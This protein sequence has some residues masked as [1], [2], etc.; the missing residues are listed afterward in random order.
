MTVETM[1]DLAVRE[2]LHSSC[3]RARSEDAF[4]MRNT[5][6]GFHVWVIDGASSI[7]ADPNQYR[8]DMT[9]PAWFARALSLLI[10]RAVGHAPLTKSTLRQAVG[11]CEARYMKRCAG[12]VPPYEYPLAAMTYAHIRQAGRVFVINQ[13]DFADC[14][15]HVERLQPTEPRPAIASPAFPPYAPFEQDGT[16]VADLRKR[17][18]AQIQDG[19]GTALTIRSESAGCGAWRRTRMLGPILLA[20]GSDGIERAW[21]S[22]GLLNLRQASRIMV[23][24]RALGLLAGM[25]RWESGNANHGREIK[26]A[27]DATLIT[28]VL[29]AGNGLGGRGPVVR[30]RRN[31]LDYRR[32]LGGLRFRVGEGLCPTV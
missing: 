19:A 5:R 14:F 28:A 6:S 20:I 1:V 26:V 18:S 21:A 31:G 25:R 9:D 10:F 16:V 32:A 4:G 2:V 3:S 13:L 22:Y 8:P 11:D 7:A 12:S 29:G 17:R 15:L 23:R 27:D 24:Q 30:V